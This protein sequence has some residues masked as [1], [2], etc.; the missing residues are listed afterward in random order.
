ML[1]DPLRAQRETIHTLGRRYGARRIRVQQRLPL[2][3]E[4]A[5]LLYRSVEVVPE[6]E[7]HRH[8]R[9]YVFM[10]AVEI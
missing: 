7:L 9:E 3:E 1:L 2:T 5:L 10:E 8:I 6:H 4:L